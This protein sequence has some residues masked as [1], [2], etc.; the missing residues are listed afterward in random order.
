M[1]RKAGLT[2]LLTLT[3][4]MLSAFPALA[5][6]WRETDQGQWQYIQDDGSK[7][8]GWVESDDNYYWLDDKGNRKSNYWVRDDG[9]WYYVDED[10]ILVTDSWVD[11]Y[12]VDKEGKMTKKR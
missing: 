10:G 11:N 4:L 1:K 12:Y 7:A 2:L 8:T 3:C 9:E 5:G 6:E